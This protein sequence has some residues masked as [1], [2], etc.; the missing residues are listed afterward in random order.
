MNK[1][2]K[3]SLLIVALIVIILI[4]A[5]AILSAKVKSKI[6]DK[7]DDLQPNT[8][9][10]YSDLDIN[11][12]RGD[13][14]F[15]D[16]NIKILGENTDSTLVIATLEQLKIDDLSYWNW[17]VNDNIL[18]EKLIITKPNITY[19]HNPLVNTEAFKKNTS[20]INK[21]IIV[22]QISVVNGK[23]E[24]LKFSN[25]AVILKT[26]TVNFTSSNTTYSAKTEAKVPITMEAFNLEVDSLFYALNDFEN[27][28]IASAK[29]TDKSTSITTLHLKTKY[30][31]QQLSNLL[32]TERDYFN[33]TINKINIANQNIGFKAN[34]KLFFKAQNTDL[35]TINAEIFR[36]KLVEDDPTKKPLYSK[37]LRDLNFDLGLDNITLNDANLTYAELVKPDEKAG[38]LH[39]KNLNAKIVNLGNNYADSTKTS[40]TI[41]AKF[42][43][44]TPIA[45]DWSFNVQD[46]NDYFVFKGEIDNLPGQDLNPFLKPNLN[47]EFKGELQKIYFTI[48]GN[49]LKSN[50]DLKTKYNNFEAIILNKRGKEKNK[51]LSGLVNLFISKNSNDNPDDFRNGSKKDVERDQTKSVFN[52]VWLNLKGGLFSAMAGDGK[53]NND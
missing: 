9:I 24:I 28:E 25:E 42:M 20:T 49:D 40:A 39:F 47:I 6:E 3:K 27:M 22:Q 2:V 21:E 23:V 41:K 29:I 15:K 30:S 33:L 14:T 48:A 43:K 26:D 51:L 34:G 35:N 37:M 46:S 32:K 38:E 19:Y 8:Q 44:T 4:I 18:V 10:T 11:T 12:F 5:F 16:L 50:I 45:I 1:I 36:D 52:F 17:F 53:K 7:I 13:V 31:K